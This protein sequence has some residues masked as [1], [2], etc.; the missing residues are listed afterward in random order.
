MKATTGELPVGGDWVYE[1]KW[2]GMRIV[3]FLDSDGLR[4]QTT[5]ELNATPSFPELAGLVDLLDGF[6]SL[7]LDG[8]VVALGADGHPSFGRLQERMH[9]RDHAE[10]ERRA[11]STPASY[12]IFDVLHIDGSDTGDL[13][14]RDRRRLLEQVVEPG[15]HW[16]LTDV[17]TGDGAELLAVITEQGLEGL[18][19]KQALSRYV[20]GKR[21]SSW[22]KVKPRHRQEFV[23]GGW[24]EG[25][26][27]RAGSVGSLLI[28]YYVDGGLRHAGSVGSGLDAGGIRHWNELAKKYTTD[29][30]PFDGPV[31]PT[32]GRRFHWMEPRFVI[33]V[34]FGEW[35]HDGQLRHP[36]YLGRRIDKDP[37]VV[38]R[39]D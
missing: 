38:V 21:S 35:T 10:A 14:F 2:D 22:R 8:E 5:N 33:E 31:M 16:R 39:E 37:L 28:G 13:P 27:G 23:V 24:V 12:V 7:I 1:I 4:L 19:A 18:I 29:E 32:A 11:R 3:S 30:S 15:A 25:K 6:S 36:S 34:A 26:D 9:V 20:E 17:H